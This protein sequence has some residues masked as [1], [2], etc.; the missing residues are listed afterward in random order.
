MDRIGR[1]SK[2]F[3]REQR[4]ERVPYKYESYNEYEYVPY[5]TSYK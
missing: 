4:V 5:G 2:N 1:G 3:K